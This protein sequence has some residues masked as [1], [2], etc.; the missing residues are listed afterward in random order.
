MIFNFSNFFSNK[1][2][3]V[4]HSNPHKKNINEIVKE[5]SNSKKIAIPEQI[6]SCIVQDIKKEGIYSDTDGLIN[7]E[8]DLILT[9]KVADCVPIFL[10]DDK[11]KNF[12]LIHSGWKGTAGNIVSNGI[13]K[14]IYNNSDSGDILAFLGPCIQSCCYEVG[15]DVSKYFDNIAKLMIKDN[16]WMLDLHSQIKMSLLDCGLQEK[17]IQCSDVCTFESDKCH[18]YRRDGENAGRMIAVMRMIK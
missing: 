4:L 2:E 9:L 5:F 18:S 14:M 13:K 6:H 16:K 1:I 17:N 3:A 12:G 11:K 7:S 10:Y 15:E 8:K